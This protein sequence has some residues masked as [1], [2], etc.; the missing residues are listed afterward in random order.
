MAKRA[1]VSG[2]PT[3]RPR[4]ARPLGATAGGPGKPAAAPATKAPEASLTEAEAQRAAALEAELV[5]QEK[6]AARA[7]AAAIAAR[8]RRAGGGHL[9]DPELLNQP[10]SVRAAHEYAY[11]ARD[12]RRIGLTAG[13]MLA[14][15][16]S[17]AFAINVVG[18]IKV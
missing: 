2:R 16:L 7:R 10:L 4:P 12:V 5:A 9:V 1:R 13:L 14:I 8:A 15:L 18:L 11:V 17:L 3:S 6:A